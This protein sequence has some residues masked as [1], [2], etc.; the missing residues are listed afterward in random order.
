[1]IVPIGNWRIIVP[2]V[3]VVAME[4][5]EMATRFKEGSLKKVA[6][7]EGK[8]WVLRVIGINP[9]TGKKVERT[10]IFVG[11]LKDFPTKSS[12]KE[13]VKRRNLTDQLNATH[14]RGKAKFKEIAA[15]YIA[16]ELQNPRVVKPKSHNTID[17]YA[18][19]I[20]RHLL[21][22]WGNC[23]A[24]EIEPLEVEQWYFEISKDSKGEVGLAWDT[25]SKLHNIMKQIYAHAQRNKLIAP[26]PKYNPVRPSELGGAR[27]KSDSDYEAVI[28]TPQETFAILNS[29]PLL[30]QT[31]VVL[32]AATGIRYAEMAGL[33]WGDCDWDN[34][35]IH[36][37]RTWSRGKVGL[38]KTKNSKAP[39][40]MAPLLAQYLRAWRSQTVFAADTDWIFA[41]N[42]TGGKSPRVGNMLVADYLRPAAVK[43]G[44][45]TITHEQGFDKQGNE[46]DKLRYWDKR[47]NE[48]K[49]FGFHNFRH[50]LASFLTTKKKTDVKTVQRSLRHKKS[51][52]TVDKYVQTDM[53]ELV[54]A[55]E[56]MLDAIFQNRSEAVN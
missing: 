14:L 34:S 15:H 10:P 38:T 48:V 53:D 42:K 28:L 25:I 44:A 52:T 12:A 2:A 49:R 39:V 5:H 56:V 32:D 22:R 37:R 45:L 27:C 30:Q 8:A 50:S 13:E 4:E 23:F 7:K 46:T 55:Q 29:L 20:R 24:E 18:G 36:I 21:D 16:S 1:M 33:L 43:A 19:N 51:A 11:Y 26:D 54:A 41:S 35:Q 17:C 6:R 47:G 9:E 3:P 31:M 40:A